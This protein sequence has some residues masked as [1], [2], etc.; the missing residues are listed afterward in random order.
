MWNWHHIYIQHNNSWFSW[1]QVLIDGEGRFMWTHTHTIP[2]HIPNVCVFGEF[3]APTLGLHITI[4]IFFNL[5]FIWN[6]IVPKFGVLPGGFLHLIIYR[7]FSISKNNLII[8]KPKWQG[9]QCD[10]PLLTITMVRVSFPELS[11]GNYS[12]LSL[13][14]GTFI[15]LD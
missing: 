2:Y 12:R 4:F 13:T 9:H 5:N 1:S 8:F 15:Q 6:T 3:N 14:R 10:T 11:V 7:K